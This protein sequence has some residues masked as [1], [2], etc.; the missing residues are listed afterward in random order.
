MYNMITVPCKETNVKGKKISW[1]PQTG[2][3][4]IQSHEES[5][6]SED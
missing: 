5:Q 3:F 2:K 4:Y 6:N 1:L